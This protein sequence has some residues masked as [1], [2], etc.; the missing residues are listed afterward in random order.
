[1]HHI[2]IYER[3][4]S[5]TVLSTSM[6]GELFPAYRGKSKKCAEIVFEQLKEAFRLP[7]ECCHRGIPHEYENKRCY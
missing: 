1:M 3:G 2:Y 4:D 5:F 6:G 7:D